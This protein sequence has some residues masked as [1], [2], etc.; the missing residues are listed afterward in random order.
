MDQSPAVAFTVFA[1]AWSRAIETEICAVLC[2]IGR[3][4]GLEIGHR[5]SLYAMT[6]A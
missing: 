5:A 4:K 2:A 6:M 3:Q 1:D